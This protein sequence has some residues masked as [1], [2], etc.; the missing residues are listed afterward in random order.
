MWFKNL[1]LYRLPAPWEISLDVLEAQLAEQ[2]FQPCGSQSMESR[3]WVSPLD[4]G[5]LAHAVG[6][7]WLIALGIESRLL[8]VAVVRQEADERA[9]A[10]AEQQGYKL[11]RKQMKELREQITQEL[12]PRA[13]TRRRRTWAWIDPARGWLAIDASSQARAEDLLEHL[14]KTLDH[15]PLAL[16][17]TQKSPASVMSGWLA[18]GEAPA[19]FTLD[20]DCELRS[21]SEDHATVRYVHHPLEGEKL[22]EEVRGH[23]EAGKLPTRLALT[24]D[25]R[26][27]FVLT[28]KLEIKRLDFLD[29]VRDQIEGGIDDAA[30]LFDAEFALMTGELVRLFPVLVDV[31]GGELE[32]A[33]KQA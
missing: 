14:R 10:L 3:G 31:L 12:L 32:Q 2:L 11:G 17:R 29:V 8:P 9:E 4:D 19:G 25:D 13:F 28:D 20:Q 33:A 30:E 21:I 23:L 15:F 1:Q 7:Q 18:A 27:S 24:F 16:L 22:T 6:G 26:V 5:I